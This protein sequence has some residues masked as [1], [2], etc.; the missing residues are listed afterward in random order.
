M[1]GLLSQQG[2]QPK[3]PVDS[4]GKD[5][6]ANVTPEEQQ[7]YDQFVTN[8]MQMLDDEKA[9]PQILESIRGDGNPVEGLA[10]ALVALVMRLE[11]SAEEQGQKISGDVM[12]HGG[13]E[14]LEQMVEIAEKAGVH[15]F[16]EKEMESALYLALD[17]YRATRQEQGKLPE[18]ALQADMQ[19]LVQADQAGGLEELI[20][21]ITKYAETAPKPDD[22]PPQRRGA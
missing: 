7:Q 21:G 3:K 16:D 14:L 5:E 17:T 4:G 8:G 9:L 13:T 15:E 11:D 10:N 20:P 1:A 22:P 6:A 18:E 19:E 2:Q 12:L